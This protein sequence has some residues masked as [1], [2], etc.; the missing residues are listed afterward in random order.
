VLAQAQ[1]TIDEESASFERLDAEL[2][3]RQQHAED[4]TIEF[5]AAESRLGAAR[6]AWRQ[7]EREAQE[8][9]FSIREIQGRIERFE[10]RV[11]QALRIEEQ[12]RVERE[13]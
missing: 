1:A 12:G 8:A 3:E 4:L 6:D 5:E 10:A 11:E 13:Q 2:A 7:V 9:S